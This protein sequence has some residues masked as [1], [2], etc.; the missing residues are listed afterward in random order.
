MRAVPIV[1]LAIM[2]VI[3]QMASSM[4]PVVPVIV[5]MV[6]VMI[7]VPVVIPVMLVRSVAVILS[8]RYGC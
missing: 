2:I 4:I 6:A 1:N 5:I 7:P 3:A 8:N